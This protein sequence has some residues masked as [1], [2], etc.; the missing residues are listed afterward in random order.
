MTLEH[1]TENPVAE[2]ATP[3]EETEQTQTTF[4]DLKV[5]PEVLETL[6]RMGYETPTEVQVDDPSRVRGEGP[7][8]P[9][10]YRHR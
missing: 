2:D 1:E 5:A 10:P 4:A 6:E 7:D 8:G 9:E 3:E